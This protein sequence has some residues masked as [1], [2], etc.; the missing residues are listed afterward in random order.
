MLKRTPL[1]SIGNTIV[2]AFSFI[3]QLFFYT[4]GLTQYM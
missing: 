4:L 1:K 3:L 2:S